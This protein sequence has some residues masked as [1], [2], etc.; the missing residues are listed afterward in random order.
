LG[1]YYLRAR[2]M[3]PTTGRFMSRDPNDAQPRNPD[4][5]PV[6][7]KK[8]H[9]YLYAG[10]DPINRIDPLGRELEEYSFESAD[11]EKVA[12]EIEA[13]KGMVQEAAYNGCMEAALEL[14]SYDHGFDV[15][16][17]DT[18]PFAYEIAKGVCKVWAAIIP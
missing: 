8:L 12:A 13:T 15:T 17:G 4:G 16:S 2:Y 14:L 3:N 7:P 6:D 11:D 9:K 18:L 1:L 10:G 5:T